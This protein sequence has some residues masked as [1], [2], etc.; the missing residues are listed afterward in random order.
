MEASTG[1]PPQRVCPNCARISWA[2]GPQCPYCLG[3]FRQR[4]VTPR[5]LALT[6]A[7]V[8]LVIALMFL[9]FAQQIEGRLDDRV[10]EAQRQ[11]DA[12]LNKFREDVRREVDA[13]SGGTGPTDPATGTD[14]A[15]TPTP[16]PTATPYPTA[17]PFAT[18]DPNAV[19]TETPFGEEDPQP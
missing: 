7:G 17:T 11:F 19:P 8:L 13:R 14:P 15:A 3:K 2:T 10:A 18:E 4:G 1:A 6:A 12:S 16:F 5:M 9:V